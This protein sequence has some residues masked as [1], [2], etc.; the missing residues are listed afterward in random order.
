[1]NVPF[2]GQLPTRPAYK[3]TKGALVSLVFAVLLIPPFY[4]YPNLPGSDVAFKI[5]MRV[6]LMAALAFLALWGGLRRD[7]R[8][9]MHVTL[10]WLFVAMAV[11]SI[12]YS[13]DPEFSAMRA[14]DLLCFVLLA[15]LL[16]ARLGG[17]NSAVSFVELALY[18]YLVGFLVVALSSGSSLMRPMGADAIARLGG[19]IVNPNLFAYCC[20]YLICISA[21]RLPE[22]GRLLTG[23]LIL[24]LLGLVYLTYSR[25]VIV[26]IA[27]S[28][29]LI[30]H[31]LKNLRLAKYLGFSLAAL[32]GLVLMDYIVTF[33]ERGHGLEN[34][35]SLG[36]RTLF[37]SDLVTDAPFGANIVYGFGYQMLSDK[38]LSAQVDI[39]QVSMAHNN[40]IQSLLG[41][42][43]VG[44]FI[45]IAFWLTLYRF[46][47]RSRRL[48]EP[49]P[50]NLVM[51]LS[52]ATLVYSMV[53]Y[54][55]FGPSTI[56]GP[57][58]FILIFSYSRQVLA[59]RSA[60]RHTSTLNY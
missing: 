42:G 29:F 55:I 28:F 31:R 27:V 37:W 54:G 10:L 24:G 12:L 5:L 3:H 60:Q 25:S 39:L 58:F 47:I 21:Y 17:F 16:S 52:H 40:F 11:L 9:G 49:R 46:M 22:R 53:E 41:L 13:S 4:V 18:L 56:I 33:L 43:L 6:L 30:R 23:F 50:Y 20:L 7:S 38:G 44:L 26:I 1:M 14:L 35:L 57:M 59:A 36:G 45:T 15:S 34:L 32:A 2:A 51:I 48:M 8:L 19:S